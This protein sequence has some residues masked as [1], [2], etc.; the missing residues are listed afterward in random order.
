MKYKHLNYTETLTLPVKSYSD[1]NANGL[2]RC[3]I[4]FLKLLDWNTE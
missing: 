4:V 2:T 1:K 3:I